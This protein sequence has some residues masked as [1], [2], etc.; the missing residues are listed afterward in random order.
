MKAVEFCYWLQGWFELGDV[1]PECQDRWV[2]RVVHCVKAHLA[3]TARTDPE[4]RNSFVLWL[5][6][7][8]RGRE[9]VGPDG[10]RV[11]RET[12]AAQFRHVIDPSY[13]GD[14]KK[15]QQIHNGPKIGGVGL[16]GQL[17]RC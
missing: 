10:V 2:T 8:M 1:A 16:D 14:A 15:L 4:H 7:Y 17:F 11:I 3:L 9:S 5:D 6:L 12:L 13:G